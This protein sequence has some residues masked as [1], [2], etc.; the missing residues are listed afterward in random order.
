MGIMAAVAAAAVAGGP[1]T[2]ECDGGGPEI[3]CGDGVVLT[4]SFIS[5]ASERRFLSC[6]L[7]L[8]ID[9]LRKAGGQ[10]LSRGDLVSPD[11]G[12]FLSL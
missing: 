3:V 2:T 9:R 6:A 10:V 5:S 1:A 4:C 7:S 11:V 12:V 8:S